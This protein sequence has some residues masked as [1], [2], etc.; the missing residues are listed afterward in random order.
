MKYFVKTRNWHCKKWVFRLLS[1]SHKI[2][3]FRLDDYDDGDGKFGYESN[4]LVKA[5]LV[6]CYFFVLRPFS[7]GWT[8][9]IKDGAQLDGKWRALYLK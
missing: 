9:I 5:F 7:G 3:T 6:F 1:L 4:S 8:Y 2:N